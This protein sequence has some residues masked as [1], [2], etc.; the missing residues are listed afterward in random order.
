MTEK[1]LALMNRVALIGSA[2]GWGAQNRMTERG[3]DFLRKN[4]LID[5][6]QQ[7]HQEAYWET[8]LHPLK[9]AKESNLP[10]GEEVLQLLIPHLEQLA[11]AVSKAIFTHDFPVVIGGD[12]SMAVGDIGGVV[13]AYN[14]QQNFGLIWID[15]HMDAHIPQTSPS[16]AYH[17]MPL[18]V[19]LGYGDPLLTN[20]IFPG[21]K[22][23]PEH[24]VVIG[25]RS[26]E[27]EEEKLLKD[28]QVRIFYDDELK[29][30]GLS[31]ILQ[32]AI[33]IVTKDTQGF[34]LSI[35]LDAFDPT[36]APGVGTPA[37]NGIKSDELFPY[38]SYIREHPQFKFLE[39]AEF[40]PDLDQNHKT[41][42]IIQRLLL[43]LL[44]RIE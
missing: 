11:Q 31:S 16:H 6:L 30:R 27:R 35:D 23:K 18:A 28:L 24:V 19:L 12:H 17:G 20:L 36:E 41:E 1:A 14:A 29:K 42:K 5:V 3:P 26:Y 8:I 7:N 34:A 40:N 37:P 10:Q 38:L 9:M 15:A 25:P 22:L 2:C 39:I 43:Q 21:P 44:P 13:E 32:E 33:E 4:G